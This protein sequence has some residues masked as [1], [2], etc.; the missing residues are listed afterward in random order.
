RPFAGSVMEEYQE[1]WF[2]RVTIS[3][4]MTV[5]FKAK[6]DREELV[7]AV[8][9]KDGT[10]RIQTILRNQNSRYWEL[11]ERFRQVTG[12]PMVLNTS[13]N[14]K[15]EPIVCTPADAIRCF[16]GCGLDYLV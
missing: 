14:V 6:K 1:Q 7:P 12:I 8:I 3:P 2:E 4:F 5:T 10:C 15:G 16:L 13:L 9:H 11:V